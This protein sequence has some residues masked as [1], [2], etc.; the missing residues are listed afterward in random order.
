M[1]L[2]RRRPSSVRSSIAD[3][4]AARKDAARRLADTRD[5]IAVQRERARAERKTIIEALR[6]IREQNNLADLIMG[7][8]EKQ[9]GG[10]DRQ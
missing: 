5:V 3:A 6:M 7:E 1:R 4:V 9:A 2:L 10:E 8:I